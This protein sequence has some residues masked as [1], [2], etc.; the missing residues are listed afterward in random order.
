[1]SERNRLD[2]LYR[3]ATA[4]KPDLDVDALARAVAASQPD[5]TLLAESSDAALAWRIAADAAPAAQALARAL[6]NEVAPVVVPFRARVPRWTWVA[7]GAAMAA[8]LAMVAIYR[9]IAD[10]HMPAGPG[11]AQS[12]PDAMP[13]QDGILAGSSFEGDESLP[14]QPGREAPDGVV[15]NDDFGS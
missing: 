15:F 1:M 13:I 6:G 2:D 11:V 12:I 8:G 10:Q 9:P 14:V 4:G 5:A 3:R 7:A